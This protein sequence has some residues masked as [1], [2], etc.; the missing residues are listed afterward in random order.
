MMM[1][2]TVADVITIFH[3]RFLP[4]LFSDLHS[5]IRQMNQ[6]KW[7][8]TLYRVALLSNCFILLTQ[9]LWYFKIFHLFRKLIG[10]R[11]LASFCVQGFWNAVFVFKIAWFE[12]HKHYTDRIITRLTIS[13]R[14]YPVV[15]FDDSYQLWS[16][17]YFFSKNSNLNELYFFLFFVLA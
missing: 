9:G 13:K 12:G 3:N 14:K 7:E 15:Q 17:G 6:S 1:I 8:L 10:N 2:M 4:A 16:N 5:I 11:Y